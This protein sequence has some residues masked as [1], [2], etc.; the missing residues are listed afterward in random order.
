MLNQQSEVRLRKIK[1]SVVF[2]RKKE[3]RE[4][5]KALIQIRAYQNRKNVF[6]S[7][8]IAISPKFWDKRN[9]CVK[10][11]HKAS[12]T[13]NQKIRAQRTKMEDFEY[14]VIE[15]C[16]Y[17][18]LDDLKKY[19]K[20]GHKRLTFTDFYQQE[21]K[22]STIKADSLKNQRTTFNKMCDYRPVVHF[23]DLSYQF[24]IGFDRHLRLQNLGLNTIAKHHR[25]LNK[26]IHLAE[27][28]GFFQS[29]RNPYKQFK[30]K[31]TEPEREF[32]NQL[33]L[34]KLEEL[35]FDNAVQHLKRLRDFFLISCWTG[36]RFSDVQKLCPRQ[37]I[38]T[39]KGLQLQTRAKK[40]DKWLNLPLYNLF[41]MEGQP[42]K[43]EQ[44]ITKL[45]EQRAQE[46]GGNKD[47]DEIPFFN[48]SNQYLNRSLKKI[49]ELAGI[50]KRL[51]SHVGR[52]T[53]ATILAT[54]VQLPILQQLL[55]HKKID[56][57]LIY[58]QLSNQAIENE[59]DKVKWN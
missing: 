23:Y 19:D 4:D 28:K 26:Y 58:V 12:R 41:K 11:T 1:Y 13:Y 35:E 57:T 59:L 51:T 30:P 18:S 36:L 29:D 2:N 43:I 15:R 25:N 32:L 27:R 46:T 50:N 22:L 14:A 40:T 38:Q 21:M 20:E 8:D 9:K 53:F 17:C 24:V 45:L 37:I 52:R 10:R 56:M 39:K 3:L 5:G 16:G 42:S 54:K 47:F 44:L 33:E 55:Q 7:T 6:F 48:I 34:N 31:Q 49:A